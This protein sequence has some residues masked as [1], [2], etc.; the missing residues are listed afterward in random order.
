M[1]RRYMHCAAQQFDIEGA[2]NVPLIVTEPIG[3]SNSGGVALA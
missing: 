1:Y 3:S 2:R